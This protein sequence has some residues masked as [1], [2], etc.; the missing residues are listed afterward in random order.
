M[1]NVNRRIAQDARLN[2]ISGFYYL[3]DFLWENTPQE[4]TFDLAMSYSK[5]DLEREL[6]DFIGRSVNYKGF[7]SVNRKFFEQTDGVLIKNNEY[8][9]I[10]FLRRMI[11]NVNELLIEK[12]NSHSEGDLSRIVLKI[13][14]DDFSS[15]KVSCT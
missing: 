5:W 4:I 2:S 8:V 12:V 15:R 7:W 13:D 3:P 11:I 9:I 10:T 14:Q 6:S 1:N